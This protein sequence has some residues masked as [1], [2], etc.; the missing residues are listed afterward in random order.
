MVEEMEVGAVSGGAA[1]PEL[2]SKGK[3]FLAAIFDLVIIPILLGVVAGLV[4]INAP[5]ALRNTLLVLV[6]VAWMTLRDIRNGAGP[7]KKMAGIKVVNAETGECPTFG[8]LVVRNITL[9]IPFVLVLGYVVEII[10]LL[11]KGER[12]ADKWA[13]TKVVSA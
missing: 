12:L 5:D 6:N 9:I 3:R 10:M 13:K 2:A 4:L 7:G 1:A 8:Q 11:V